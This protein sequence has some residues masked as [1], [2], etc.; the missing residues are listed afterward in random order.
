MVE[1]DLAMF[2]FLTFVVVL[3]I[4]FA[5][6]GLG[7]YLKGKVEKSDKVA[8]AGSAVF[9]FFGFLAATL[10]LRMMRLGD[11]CLLPPA[12]GCVLISFIGFEIGYLF[13][14]TSSYAGGP[15]VAQ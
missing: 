7:I 5:E 14:T 13:G 2:N 9:I 15:G 1:M 11:A 4:L 10:L 3:A 8:A 12:L 6:A